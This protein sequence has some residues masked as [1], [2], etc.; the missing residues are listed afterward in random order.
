[1]GA[2]AHAH[3]QACPR[4]DPTTILGEAPAATNDATDVTAVP[5]ECVSAAD[6]DPSSSVS[7][8]S[9]NSAAASAAAPVTLTAAAK[10]ATPAAADPAA[11]A[12]P[13]LRGVQLPVT[14]AVSRKALSLHT[15]TMCEKSEKRLS[16]LTEQAEVLARWLVIG[17]GLGELRAFSRRHFSDSANFRRLRKRSKSFL[18]AR[19]HPLSLANRMRN[20]LCSVVDWSL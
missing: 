2:Q 18:T 3:A 19:L 9:S 13:P 1:M 12:A 8:P 17:C 20:T 7:L 5:S 14:A 15:D 10:A 16:Q 11:A 4:K 6:V